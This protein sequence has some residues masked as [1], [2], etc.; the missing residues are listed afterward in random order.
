MEPFKTLERAKRAIESLNTLTDKQVTVYLRGGIYTLDHTLT[1]SGKAF[2]SNGR[3]VVW[4]SYK[5]EN[6]QI[7]GGKEIKGFHSLKDANAIKRINKIYQDKIVEINLKELGI[8]DFGAITNRGGPG[9][10][11]FFND[12]KMEP[13]RW[14]NDG[15]ARI[16][17]VPQVGTMVYNGDP[18]QNRG[19]IPAG[20]HYGGFTYEGDRPTHWSDISDIALHGYWTWDWYD[21]YLNIHSIDTTT[22][23][24]YIKPPHS[25]YGYSSAQRYYAANVLEELDQPGEWYINRSTGL[26]L[27][28]PPSE[29][30]HATIMISLL[31]KPLIQ[32]DNTDGVKIENLAFESS[33]GSGIVIN[34][35]ENNQIAGCS[36]CNLGDIAVRILG[37]M[38]NGVL[39]C[40]IDNIA[41]AGIE[42]NGGDRKSLTVGSNYVMN[43]S[44]H[45][46]AQWIRTY[47]AAVTISGVGNRISNNLIY[48]GPGTGILLNGNEHIIEYNEM[49][50][51][52]LETGD[53]GAFYMGRDWTQRGNIIRYNYFHDLKGAGNHDVNAVYLDDWTSGMTVQGNIFNN[54]ARGVMIGGGRDNIVTNNIFIGCKPAVHV[55]SRGLGWAKYYF[56]GSNKTLFDGM[57]A[58]NYK[59]PPYSEKYPELLSLINDDPAVAK[60]NKILSNISDG[61]RWMDL[62]DNLD[63]K[64]VQSKDNIIAKP[65]KGPQSDKDFIVSNN[66]GIYNA[67]KK[68]FRIK[69]EGFQHGFKPIDYSKIGLQKDSFRVK[70]AKS[71]DY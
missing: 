39:S 28:W 23:E 53:V 7:I 38:N 29:I 57:D 32:L 54:C 41:I 61:G 66:P 71:F 55:D 27:F 18:N 25:V 67:D 16:A 68:D 56:D 24:I 45:D 37:G 70:P 5:G 51:L 34:G 49:H 21:E 63:F 14:P 8:T 17:D 35:G 48:N 42:L 11:L 12:R 2:N 47:Q 65:E 58:M 36:F 3:S 19:G 30:E 31:D 40:D 43:N 4:K 9:M 62:E 52:A 60:H 1:M 59:Q 44:I 10:E 33:R 26:L 20:R 6:V 15:W 22:H 69:P 50:D 64:I 13:A 46:F